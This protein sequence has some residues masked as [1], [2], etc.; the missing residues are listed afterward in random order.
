MKKAKSTTQPSSLGPGEYWPDV[1]FSESRELPSP[2][3]VRQS[4]N[5]DQRPC[6]RCGYGAYRDHVFERV[7]HDIGDLASGRPREIHLTYSQHYCTHCQTYFSDTADLAPPRSRY[8]HRV[9][10]LSVR[11]VAEDGLPYRAVSWL[12]WQ[13][14]RVFVPF[15]TLQNWAEAAGQRAHQQLDLEYLEWALADFSGYI[16]ADELYDG[17]FCVLSIVDNRTFKRVAYQV[18]DHDPTHEDIVAFF[19]RFQA[20]LEARH[21]TLQGITTDGSALYPAA[22]TTVFGN[23]PH[24]IC[25][26][27]ILA[28]L[29][30]AVL[31]AV[32]KVRKSLADRKPHLRR[33][34]PS[35]QTRKLAQ[36]RE[37]LEQKI[38]DL[39]TDRHLFVQRTLT[40]SER[41]T[42]LRI[43]RGLPHLRT[44]RDIMDEVYRLFDRR[45]RTQTAL[46]KLA[47][48]R[49]RVQRFTSV[50]KTLQALFSANVEK[51]LTF[52]D[53]RLLPATSNAVE[54]GNRRYR[55]MQKTIYRAR[56]QAH[57]VGRLA[58]DLF[59]DMFAP[60][61]TS[62]MQRLH[63][64]RAAPTGGATR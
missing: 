2:K 12:L 24:Q 42:L 29:T 50:G 47:H 48:L 6:P 38:S 22:I 51:A 46:T 14:H 3:I 33:G 60:A 18:L 57:I 39:F 31:R 59:R 8:T 45:C 13:D 1:I 7:L 25:E 56:T 36:Q 9:V 4:R 41:N 20:A 55:K 21:L 61:R 26:F 30:Q 19:R 16:A 52:L 63:L 54:R 35:Q 37:R 34:R 32:A 44:L 53:D 23:I 58:L 62:I 27:H 15:A 64:S 5:Y 10:D 28:T 49:Q 40:S 17:P 11:L 43:T